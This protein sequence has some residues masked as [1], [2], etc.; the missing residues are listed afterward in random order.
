MFHLLEGGKVDYAQYLCAAR[1]C[2]KVQKK[3]YARYQQQL[4]TKL[5]TMSNSDKNFW[6]VVNDVAGLSQERSAACPR[7]DAIVDHFADKMSNGGDTEATC[8]EVSTH[9]PV[10]LK[11]WRV[12]Y[13]QVKR[14]LRSLDPSKSTNGVG[15][16]FLRECANAA[17][18]A[19]TKLFKF[20][21]RK[22]KLPGRWKLG[23]VTPLH[24]RGSVSNE[25][26]YRPVTVLNNASTSLENVIEEQFYQWMV[27]FIPDEQYGFLKDCG[28][29]DYGAR[30]LFTMLS[31]LE[32]R[33]EGVLIV[34]DVK[35]AFDRCWWSKIK[36]RLRKAG[37]TG[38][39][40]KLIKNYLFRRF[41]EV[42]C[43]GESSGKREIFSGV[44]QG[45]KL[46]PLIW[47]FDISE[48]PY[49]VG[50]EAELGAYA[51]DLWIWYEVTDLNRS[52]LVDTINQDLEH[53]MQWS[54]ENLT[55]FE[56]DKTYMMVM[57]NKD[58]PFNP[59]GI[60]MGGFDVKVVNEL[61][62]TGFVFDHKLLWGSHISKV[63]KK[64]RQRVGALRNLVQYLSP[65]NMQIMYTTFIRSILEYGSVLFMGASDSHLKKLDAVQHTA[66]R[67]GGFQVESLKSRR[68]AAA[69]SLALKLLAGDCKPGLQRFA[70]ELISGHHVGH[71]HNTSTTLKMQ[72]MRIKPIVLQKRFSPLNIFRDSFLGQI[73]LIW[74]KLP[75]D[76]LGVGQFKGW[77]K[78]S[79]DCKKFLKDLDD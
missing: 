36:L 2:R 27:H 54:V 3:A 59:A 41:I 73:H 68:E 70:P 69:I 33:G 61:K 74:S 67:L 44:P 30:L 56:P 58:K 13:R 10:V 11:C 25:K 43:N 34:L 19:T 76:M 14:V 12:R 31:V 9:A 28:T 26:N 18:P 71:D 4:K 38:R 22:S 39:A 75:Q 64:A 5:S 62:V 20:I 48:L 6:S 63:V 45:G 79:K 40:L 60:V 29:T 15:P 50:E 55:T 1:V 51:D 78:I 53:L 35:G 32:R 47:D 7:V 65:D 42:V 77:R 37:M 66:E 57:S 16:R 72:G 21:V 23:R 17:A 52:S 24:K 46:S 49:A 8:G